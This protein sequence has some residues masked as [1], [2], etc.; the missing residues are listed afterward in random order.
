MKIIT[1]IANPKLAEEICR[2]PEKVTMY[3]INNN[4]LFVKMDGHKD[5][6]LAMFKD[7]LILTNEKINV[8]FGEDNLLINIKEYHG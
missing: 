5:Q 3:Y 2:E 4:N 6:I 8:K 1:P 7:T